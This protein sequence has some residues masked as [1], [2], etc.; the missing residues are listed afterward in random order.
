MKLKAVMFYLCAGMLSSVVL[1]SAFAMDEKKPLTSHRKLD[2]YHAMI[3][4]RYFQTLDDFVNL[5]CTNKKFRGVTID[6]FHYNPISVNPRTIEKWK[7]I[8]TL[9]IYNAGT[10][11]QWRMYNGTR[12]FHKIEYFAEIDYNIAKQEFKENGLY[13]LIDDNGDAVGITFRDVFTEWELPIRPPLNPKEPRDDDFEI[14]GDYIGRIDPTTG[15]AI[16]N[17]YVY[18]DGDVAKSRFVIRGMFGNYGSLC[19]NLNLQR[20]KLPP[21]IECLDT[22][23][24]AFCQCSNLE[25]LDLSNAQINNIPEACCDQCSKLTEI[26]LPETLHWIDDE[27][28]QDCISLKKLEIPSG[29]FKTGNDF[30]DGCTSLTELKVHNGLASIVYIANAKCPN[31]TVFVPNQMM[32]NQI[33]SEATWDYIIGLKS[34]NYF[35]SFWHELHNTIVA[36]Y[37]NN[38]LCNLHEAIEDIRFNLQENY[39]HTEDMLPEPDCPAEVIV[40]ESLNVDE[41]NFLWPND[42]VIRIPEYLAKDICQS[43]VFHLEFYGR[44]DINKI[45]IPDNVI[46]IDIDTLTSCED[47]VTIEANSDIEIE[48]MLGRSYDPEYLETPLNIILR[49]KRDMSEKDR[50]NVRNDILRTFPTFNVDFMDVD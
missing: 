9:Y 5:E 45:I 33:L 38:D 13:R 35:K 4:S 10:L 29:V 44:K 34:Y 17:K 16:F 37:A 3:V 24:Y 27:A 23:S 19:N 30:I 15:E 49:C 2:P 32:K 40:D 22:E 28:F 12:R 8:E 48:D 36:E 50:N 41:F 1:K 20:I 26:R 21:S 6:R 47:N 42:G 14:K 25:N 18:T 7:N 39:E 11:N 43:G 46:S 31:C